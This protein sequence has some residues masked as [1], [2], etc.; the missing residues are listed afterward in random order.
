M[1]E[2][3]NGSVVKSVDQ[4]VLHKS[5]IRISRKQT[6]YTSLRSNPSALTLPQSEDQMCLNLIFPDE[7][8]YLLKSIR[9]LKAYNSIVMAINI[10]WDLKSGSNNW[11]KVCQQLNTSITD[12]NKKS[13][14]LQKNFY[15]WTNHYAKVTTLSIKDILSLN[16]LK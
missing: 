6:D 15:H 1:C 7:E 12:S 11:E 5:R 13:L 4:L 9:E 14:F 8:K 3:F 2:S 16:R 10:G